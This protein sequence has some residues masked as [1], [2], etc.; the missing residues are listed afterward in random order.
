MRLLTLDTRL[1]FD[2]ALRL[3]TPVEVLRDDY[4]LPDALT[5]G[6]LARRTD[7]P[8]AAINALLNGSPIKAIHAHRLATTFDTSALYWMVLQSR[9]DLENARRRSWP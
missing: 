5:A 1:H 8:R 7:I 6:A 9:C 2:P 3:R 4:M